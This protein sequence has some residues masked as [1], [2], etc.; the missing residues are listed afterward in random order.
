MLGP[1]GAPAGMIPFHKL[2]QWLTYSLIEP[3]E[4]FGIKFVDSYLLTGL[5][6]VRRTPGLSVSVSV[7]S[8]S[9]RLLIESTDSKRLLIENTD[10]LSSVSGHLALSAMYVY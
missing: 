5:A 3:F 7:F 2:A 9:K 8:V 10:P 6:E 4:S 1:A